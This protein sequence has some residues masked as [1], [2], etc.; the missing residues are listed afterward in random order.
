[1][2][3][4]VMSPKP[5]KQILSGSHMSACCSNLHNAPL[6]CDTSPRASS[7]PS[8]MASHSDRHSAQDWHMQLE[9]SDRL[10]VGRDHPPFT[11]VFDQHNFFGVL[12]AVQ[13]Q[14]TR[15][16]PAVDQLC[17]LES[18]ESEK[19]SCF[20]MSKTHVDGKPNHEFS[21]WLNTRRSHQHLLPSTGMI[22]NPQY[23]STHNEKDVTCTR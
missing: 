11:R 16:M 15:K 8:I 14:Q 4:L 20:R 18:F 10:A 23:D 22:G 3:S 1:M 6:Q 19:P 17:T 2:W 12:H 13:S 7:R 5:C 21:I 9:L